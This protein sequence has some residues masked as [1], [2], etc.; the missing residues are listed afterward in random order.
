MDVKERN[1]EQTDLPTA[2]EG[3]LACVQLHTDRLKRAESSLVTPLHSRFF[4]HTKKTRTFFRDRVSLEVPTEVFLHMQSI[5]DLHGL[6][7]GSAHCVRESKRSILKISPGIRAK[8]I[9][10]RQIEEH[11]LCLLLHNVHNLFVQEREFIKGTEMWHKR[12]KPHY[13]S[14]QKTNIL[15]GIT[16]GQHC[17]RVCVLSSLVSL[18]SP[19]SRRRLRND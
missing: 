7:S 15:K 12:T 3:W 8:P 4:V 19:A 2:P 14:S 13:S 1:Q 9:E 6:Q 16:T 5:L 18:Y 10:L 11:K 17:M